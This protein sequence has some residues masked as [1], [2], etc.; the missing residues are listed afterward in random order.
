MSSRKPKSV[1]L[2]HD[3]D[4]S[5]DEALL[6]TAL[7]AGLQQSGVTKG[8]EEEEEK[9]KKK[10][11]LRRKIKVASQLEIEVSTFAVS[12]IRPY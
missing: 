7:G 10:K 5:G 9:K 3:L 11:K 2:R 6:K 1:I 4:D 12:P 8:T